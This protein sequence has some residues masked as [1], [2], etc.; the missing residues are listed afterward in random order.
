MNEERST[1]ISTE[2]RGILLLSL[3]ILLLLSLISYSGGIEAKNW[4]GLS[5]YYAAT[6][7]LYAFGLA[8]YLVVLAIG[9]L[10]VHE[11][12][13]RPIPELRLKT[14]YFVLLTASLCV[15]LNLTVD[16]WPA[17]GSKMK[18][19]VY[20]Q[21]LVKPSFLK[22]GL[23]R[24]NLGGV[25]GYYLM[26][27]LPKVNFLR[28]FSPVGTTLIFSILLLISSLLLTE[29]GFTTFF[30]AVGRVFSK[31]MKPVRKIRSSESSRAQDRKSYFSILWNFVKRPFKRKKQ[32]LADFDFPIEEPIKEPLPP[33]K[34]RQAPFPIPITRRQTKALS[35]SPSPTTD[36][37][38]QPPSPPATPTEYSA[39]SLSLLQSPKEV[40]RSSLRR[41]LQ[42][43]AAIL[44]ETL[45]SFGIEAKVGNINAG[46]TIISYEV[47]PSTGVKVQK[48]KALENDIALKLKA[49][50]IRII[51]PIPGRAAVGIEV[52]NPAPQEVSFKELLSSYKKSSRQL[53]VPILLGKSVVGESVISDL[54]KMPHCIIAGATGSGKSVCINTIIMSILMTAS[55]DRI[56]LLLI[57]PKKVELSAYSGLPHMI[58]PVVTEP[59]EALLAM[60]WLV[61]EMEWRYELLKQMN[62]RNIMGFNTRKRN[63]KI[64][65]SLPIEVPA[66]LPY[67]VCIIDELADL[68]MVAG[69]DIEA[70]IA[71]I[72]QMA[73]AVGIHLILATQRP[74]R[75]VITGL[76][77]ANFPTRIAFKVA[78]RVNSQIIL[79]DI[80]AESLLGNGD[81]LF[82][83][84][85]AASPVRAQGAFV[86]DEDILS[87]IESICRK[88]PTQYLVESFS[89]RSM[90]IEASPRGGSQELDAL[91]GQ[92]KRLVIETG[93]A[94]TT[95]IQRKLKVGYARAAS[96]MDQ[97]EEQS[98]I[99]PQEGS[100][101]RKVL[102]SDSEEE[103]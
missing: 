70:P 85:G 8:S 43:Q 2:I 41:F 67:Y 35:H 21:E 64:E 50:C 95:F 34:E 97:L 103:S 87:V 78:S 9:Y 28:L 15:L 59:S 77:K 58:S 29:V 76:I 81:M 94:S 5:G 37:P 51:A 92:A 25:P 4:L 100:K 66:S 23:S 22:E 72:A 46:P 11:I 24:H 61:R 91:F 14:L 27:D 93:N 82:L 40:D 55:P 63:I 47:T 45:H 71:R 89:E 73:R 16:H 39:P 102:V 3:S 31:L 101:P 20:T 1:S 10:G 83:A 26:K 68:M 7:L 17:V 6:A 98:I 30:A 96:I 54:V 69:N 62:V 57:D 49:Q 99:G 84:P 18:S 75:E 42:E 88:F 36:S 56:R 12:L 90:E 79:D 44:E 33:V 13:A 74:S 53:Q 80:G 19:L 65:E 38:T 52:P 32:A 86:R 60:K 48:I